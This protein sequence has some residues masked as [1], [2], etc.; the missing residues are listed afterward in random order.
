VRDAPVAAR[1]IRA[2]NLLVRTVTA[3]NS[4]SRACIVCMNARLRAHAALPARDKPPHLHCVSI[5]ARCAHAYARCPRVHI[6]VIIL[7]HCARRL[8]LCPAQMDDAWPML[9]PRGEN[10]HHSP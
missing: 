9:S 3:C 1:V 4:F 10:H 8:P 7:Q 6:H 2:A 5:C